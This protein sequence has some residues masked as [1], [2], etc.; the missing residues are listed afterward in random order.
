[1]A[2]RRIVARTSVEVDGKILWATRRLIGAGTKAHEADITTLDLSVDGAKVL[3]DKKHALPPGAS[4]R[5]V[6]GSE[7]SPARVLEVI[8]ARDHNQILRL[9][10]ELPDRPFMAVIEQWL[11]SNAGGKK[12]AESYWLAESMSAEPTSDGDASAA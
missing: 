3:L 2:E 7:S 8:E 5:I 1:V 11:A 12:F 6:F 4:V 10:L 9:N